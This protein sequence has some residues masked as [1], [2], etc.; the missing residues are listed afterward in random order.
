MIPMVWHN[1]MWTCDFLTVLPA[2]ML[3]RQA[4]GRHTTVLGDM[5]WCVM[6]PPNG[7]ALPQSYRAGDKAITK[8]G[9][10]LCLRGDRVEF[11]TRTSL[12]HTQKSGRK[13]DEA[14]K[15]TVLPH[16]STRWGQA[17]GWKSIPSAATVCI[18]SVTFVLRAPKSLAENADLDN[19]GPPKP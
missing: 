14:C 8:F 10:I 3:S 11:Q 19:Q 6:V 17:W 16:L 9:P 15:T 1:R 7:S 18:Y 12:K 2:P 13:F 5:R 4:A